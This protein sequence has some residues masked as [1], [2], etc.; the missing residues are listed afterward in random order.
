MEK[1]TVILNE[2]VAIKHNAKEFHKVHSE[3]NFNIY[4]CDRAFRIKGDGTITK[5]KQFNKYRYLP[6]YVYI[7]SYMVKLGNAYG[8]DLKEY[9]IQQSKIIN[10]QYNKVQLSIARMEQDGII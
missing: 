1:E 9:C 8:H 5:T 10:E 7:D 3:D 2:S 6:I 4:T